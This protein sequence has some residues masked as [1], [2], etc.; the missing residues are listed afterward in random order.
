VQRLIEQPT[1]NG[2]LVLRGVPLGRVHYHLAVYQHFADG[3]DAVPAQLAVEGRIGA[4]VIDLVALQHAG[5]ELT[6]RL[7]DGRSLDLRV[8]HEDGTIHSTARGLYVAPA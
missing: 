8:T 3:D 5:V 6:L 4:E 2:D 7:A 1:G